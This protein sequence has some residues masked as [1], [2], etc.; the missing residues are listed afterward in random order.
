[1]RINRT[2]VVTMGLIVFVLQERIR[3][4]VVVWSSLLLTVAVRIK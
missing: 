4:E 3:K 1:M 2:A